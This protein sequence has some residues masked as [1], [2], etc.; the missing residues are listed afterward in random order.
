MWQVN[1]IKGFGCFLVSYD[2]YL[3][4]HI[5]VSEKETP[6]VLIWMQC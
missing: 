3:H 2:T 4:E 1:T 5:A 6:A